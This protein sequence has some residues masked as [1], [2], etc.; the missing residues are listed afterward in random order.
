ML[1]SK[2]IH[3]YNVIDQNLTYYRLTDENISSEFKKFTKKWWNRRNEAHE[4][5]HDFMKKNNLRTRKNLDFYITKI[6]NKII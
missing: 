2:Y 4:Y 6:V 5:F 1:F 3:K